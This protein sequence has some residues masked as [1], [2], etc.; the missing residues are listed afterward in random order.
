MTSEEPSKPPFDM[1]FGSSFH[2]GY[3]D[4]DL[5]AIQ[6]GT[7]AEIDDLELFASKKHLMASSTPQ[8]L[9]N[10]LSAKWPQV[11][12][13]I[14]PLQAWETKAPD[15][16]RSLWHFKIGIEGTQLI[17]YASDFNKTRAKHICAMKLLKKIF[18]DGFTWNRVVEL[19]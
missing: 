18:C 17:G 6:Q 13:L 11:G 12:H 5:F 7:D 9:L 2:Q 1:T 4:E 8:S 15:G 10:Q 14:K 19:L 3:T 16:K